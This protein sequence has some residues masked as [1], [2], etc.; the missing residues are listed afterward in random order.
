MGILG[1]GKKKTE[2]VKSPVSKGMDDRSE[3]KGKNN[4]IIVI[5]DS[6]R[7]DSFMAAEPQSITKLGKVEKRYSY[8][9]WTAPS[10]SRRVSAPPTRWSSCR[11]ERS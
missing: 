9:S 5:L 11:G 7:Y 10:P 2:P 4:F 6:C 8:A 3:P 1:F